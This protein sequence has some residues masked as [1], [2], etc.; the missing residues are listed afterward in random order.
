MAERHR[1][2]LGDPDYRQRV[3]AEAEQQVAG[4]PLAYLAEMLRFMQTDGKKRL[5]YA[6]RRA[7]LLRAADELEN[8]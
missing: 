6:M 2:Q 4:W 3:D 5:G 1:H 7:I 8:R